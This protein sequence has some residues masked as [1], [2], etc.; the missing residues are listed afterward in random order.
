MYIYI[1]IYIYACVYIYVC[2]HI[3]HAEY[4]KR[5]RYR[6]Q[7]T[8]TS[9]AYW[10][11]VCVYICIYI[12][13]CVC[14][15]IYVCVYICVCIYTCT[16]IY[17]TP[18]MPHGKTQVSIDKDFEGVVAGCIKQHGHSWLHQPLVRALR[19]PDVCVYVC[20]CVCEC[21][22]SNTD[23]AG[24]TSRSCAHCCTRMCVHCCTQH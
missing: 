21:V 24:C 9:R 18:S 23:T 5:V 19:Y 2:I 15:F 6:C 16:Y 4:S 17:L 14:V 11:G 13:M 22:S 7:L 1:Y 10:R 12:Y 3:F 20:V 8:K